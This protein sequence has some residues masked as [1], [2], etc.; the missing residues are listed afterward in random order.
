MKRHYLR[1]ILMK[2]F[3]SLLISKSFYILLFLQTD[4]M[5]ALD[6]TYQISTMC[7]Y[8]REQELTGSRHLLKI[9][10]S[11]QYNGFC[12]FCHLYK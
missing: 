10:Y 12:H 9:Q 4:S 2:G 7:L 3:F 5:T 1:V 8:Y 11:L 6:L